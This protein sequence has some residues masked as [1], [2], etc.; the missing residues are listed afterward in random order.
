MKYL[1]AC[2]LSFVS[3]IYGLKQRPKVFCTMICKQ[4]SFVSLS[5]VILLYS[6][7]LNGQSR[8]EVDMPSR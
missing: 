1:D 8:A 3:M 2:Y 7:E 5:N 4:Y 6:W